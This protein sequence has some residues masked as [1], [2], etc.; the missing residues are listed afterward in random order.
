MFRQGVSFI[1]NSRKP[2]RKRISQNYVPGEQSC[3]LLRETPG[4]MFRGVDNSL[5]PLESH[6]IC[7]Q[8][9]NYNTFSFP[10]YYTFVLQDTKQYQML[11]YSLGRHSGH[12]N[13]GKWAEYS[14][15]EQVITQQCMVGIQRLRGHKE[16]NLIEI[17]FWTA[18]E[19]TEA[20]KEQPEENSWRG[21]QGLVSS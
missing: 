12:S 7:I 11:A 5:S 15:C 18:Q 14:R 9:H 3:G 13:V 17:S 21:I 19:Q 10:L 20:Y 4:Q 8:L 2:P 16:E 6:N 1:E